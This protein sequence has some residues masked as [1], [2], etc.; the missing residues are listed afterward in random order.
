MIAINI[1]PKLMLLMLMLKEVLEAKGGM[2]CIYRTIVEE[3][4]QLVGL[5]ESQLHRENKDRIVQFITDLK[6]IKSPKRKLLLKVLLT[7]K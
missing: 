7:P 3:Q 6:G 4:K 1:L 5:L 2:E